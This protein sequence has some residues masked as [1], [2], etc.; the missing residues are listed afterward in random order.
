MSSDVSNWVWLASHSATCS[1]A[2][3]RL[4][5]LQEVGYTF[6]DYLGFL[7]RGPEGTVGTLIIMII[8]A[9]YSYDS[10]TIINLEHTSKGY[11]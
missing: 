11:W 10:C 1:C 9:P 6:K 5:D 7:R 3:I 2:H 8:V 4:L